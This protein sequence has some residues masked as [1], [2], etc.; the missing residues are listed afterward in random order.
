MEGVISDYIS[1]EILQNR[2]GV[3]LSDSTNLVN[4][5]LLDS[6]SIFTLINFLEERFGVD[7]AAEDVLLENFETVPAIVRFVESKQQEVAS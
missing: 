3:V 4:E 1:Q 2:P 6:L 7:V 5:H